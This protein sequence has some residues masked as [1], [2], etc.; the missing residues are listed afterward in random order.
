MSMDAE[1]EVW[2]REWQSENA[3]PVDL[4]RT[5]ERQSRW[6]RVALAADILVTVAIGGGTLA[7]AVRAPRADLI[8]LA[9][10]T[11]LFLAAAWAF[12][13]A[14]NRGAWSPAALDTAAFVELSVRR[15]RGRLA[16]VWFGAGLYLA[17][18]AF[19]VGW[20]YRDSAAPRKPLLAWLCFGPLNWVW[21]VT[22][23]FFAG[24]MWYRRKKRAE[25]TWLLGLCRESSGREDR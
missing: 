19:C 10:G 20:I 14:V 4:R 16:A 22:V 15:C 17:E 7:L 18:I 12:S 2:R 23:V 11:W 6:M 5:V 1:L 8:V 25:L 9:V 13:L 24:L 3:V 21:A